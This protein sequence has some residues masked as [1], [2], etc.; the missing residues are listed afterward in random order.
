MVLVRQAIPMQMEWKDQY[1]LLGHFIFQ[2]TLSMYHD[3]SVDNEMQ[4]L[5][6]VHELEQISTRIV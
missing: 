5:D 4:L 6:V 1:N 2:P 3:S